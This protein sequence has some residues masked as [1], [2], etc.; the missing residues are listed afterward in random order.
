MIALDPAGRIPRAGR[1]MKMAEALEFEKADELGN[2]IKRLT[3]ATLPVR[4]P[5]KPRQVKKQRIESTAITDVAAAA[6]VLSSDENDLDYEAT[7]P[8]ESEDSAPSEC[9]SVEMVPSNAEVGTLFVL[10]LSH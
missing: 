5:R 1:G 8:A 9:D 3:A 10:I 7:E 6:L 4:H 2:P